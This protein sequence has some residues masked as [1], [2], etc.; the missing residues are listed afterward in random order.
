MNPLSTGRAVEQLLLMNEISL[1]KY[2]HAAA[3]RQDGVNT[4]LRPEGEK[5]AGRLF[6]SR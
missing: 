3:S 5:P 6:N 2:H 1:T 4:L